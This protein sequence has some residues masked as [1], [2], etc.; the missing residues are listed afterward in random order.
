MMMFVSTSPTPPDH[1]GGCDGGSRR[2]QQWLAELGCH[3]QWA[4]DA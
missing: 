3:V 1:L 4:T 2:A